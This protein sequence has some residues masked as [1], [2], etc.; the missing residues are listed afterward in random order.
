MILDN[1][2]LFTGT[3]NGASGGVTSSSYADSFAQTANTYSCS[4]ILD[5]GVTSGVPSSAN[6]GGARDLGI[7]D[8]PMLKLLVRVGTAGVSAGG[9]TLQ[10]ELAGAPDN[11]SG[12]AGSY[13][14]MW[15][16]AA[17]TMA[18]AYAGADLANIDVPRVIA[19]QVLPRF[20]RL[21]FIVASATI[22][23]GTMVG[24]IVVDRDDQILGT[25]G[26]MGGYPAGITVSN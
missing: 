2:L 4:N 18:Q 26:V 25:T 22:T 13:T 15:L 20:L 1:L 5:L 6:G 9:G 19:G 14:V 16:S 7:G 8:D 24:T 10:L 11:G 17:Y 3:S 21:R 12:A 23:A